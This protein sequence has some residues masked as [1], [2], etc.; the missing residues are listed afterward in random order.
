MLSP[1]KKRFKRYWEDQRKGGK[2]KYILVYTLGWGIITFFLFFPVFLFIFNLSDLLHLDRLPIWVALLLAFA[3]GFAY[4]VF[5]WYS[6]EEKW[7]V[8]EQ[9]EMRPDQS[10]Y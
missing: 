2:W 1:Q 6:N 8:L 3:L 7:R 4:S 9:K 5:S 10:V